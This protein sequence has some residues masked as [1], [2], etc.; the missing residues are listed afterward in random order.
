MKEDLQSCFG[1]SYS[2]Y[3]NF[4]KVS[5]GYSGVAVLS[6][7]QPTAIYEDFELLGK[8]YSANVESLEGRMLT[9]DFKQCYIV[10]VY[11]PNAGGE[12]NRLPF[13]LQYSD[14][15]R[16]Y[17]SKLAATKGVVV[18]GDLNVAHE[19]IDLTYPKENRQ[20]AGFTDL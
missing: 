5:R 1:D 13:K 19:E 17:L 14:L 8:E 7:V 18:C 15:F 12:L 6:R 9:L 10:S 11:K 3:F 4:C 2:H 16:R 20:T